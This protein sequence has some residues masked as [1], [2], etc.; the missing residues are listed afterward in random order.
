MDSR[1]E[2]RQ[3]WLVDYRDAFGTRRAKQFARKKDAEAWATKASWE[4]SQGI[5]TPDSQSITVKAAADLWI[6]AAEANGRERSTIKQYK[7]LKRLH[8]IP[9]IGDERLSQLT[10]PKVEAFKDRLLETRSRA[11]AGKAVRGLSSI[12]NEAQRRGLVAQ[13]VA[14][15]VKVVRPSREKTRI[16]IP[17]REQLKAML[18]AADDDFRPMLL[19]AIVTGLR[20]SEL[21][22]LRWQDIDLKRGVVSVSQRA[23]QWGMLGLPKSSAGIRDIPIAPG[24]VKELKAWKLRCPNSELAFPNSEGGVLHHSNL[25]RRKYQPT[26]E[27]AGIV[28]PFGMHALRHAAASAWIKQG[29]DLKRLSTWMGH[30]SVQITL[31]TYG[32]LISDRR[33]DKEL[34]REAAANLI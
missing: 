25:L 26:Q 24:V 15:G 8:I 4:V 9:L 32:H 22:G 11:M 13:N 5:H 34:A 2:A 1:G 18:E 23:D 10:M 31:D 20:S 27:D 17:T 16:Q 7:E 30:S 33:M 3:A 6:K 21:R 19:T 29:I 28:K 14:K 12:L